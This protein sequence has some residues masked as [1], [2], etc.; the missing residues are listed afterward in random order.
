MPYRIA[1]PPEPEPPDPE[2]AYVAELRAVERRSRA[3]VALGVA[4]AGVVGV[5]AFSVPHGHPTKDTRL[6]REAS[7]RR[8]ADA[9][10]LARARAHGAQHA[11]E[12]KMREA[13]GAGVAPAPELGACEIELPH[14]KA[15]HGHPFPVLVMTGTEVGR[16]MPSQAVAGMLA[17]VSRAEE[18]LAAGRS[19]EAAIFARALTKDD[20]LDYDVV[21]VASTWR[22]PKVLGI[23]SYEPGEATGR[24]Y[25]YRFRDQRVIC[26]ADVHVT[27]SKTVGYAYAPAIDALPSQ[28]R[29]RS[30]AEY[31]DD[32]LRQQLELA[33]ADGVTRAR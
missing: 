24:A 7:A 10:D 9:I 18:H 16:E 20:R 25:V 2:A 8:A 22:L 14:P 30:M 27:S 15:F 32:D 12:T 23:D 17:D 29:D 13:I 26:A 6:E 4:L 28:S 33:I 21:L 19:E 31:L 3:Y 1:A 11:F 5:A